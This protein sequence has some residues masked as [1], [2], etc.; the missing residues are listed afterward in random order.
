MPLVLV[1]LGVWRLWPRIEKY[2]A[3][4][5]EA[6]VIGLKWIASLNL[7][8]STQNSSD[9]EEGSVVEYWTDD[10]VGVF[11]GNLNT[12]RRTLAE[13]D[14]A[15]LTPLI[16]KPVPFHGYY[17]LA[18]EREYTDFPPEAYPQDASKSDRKVL[19]LD[20]FA[21]CAY[22]AEY[23]LRHRRTFIVDQ[24]WIVYSVNNGGKPVTEWPTDAEL[25]ER[26]SKLPK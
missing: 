3:K 25:A 9:L 12:R 17:F 6:A 21:I 10:V 2:R 20:G 11:R 24:D 22:P 5:E 19:N 8:Y 4:D 18:L 16:P 13:A 7:F 1:G 14:A 15:P 26:F 23:D